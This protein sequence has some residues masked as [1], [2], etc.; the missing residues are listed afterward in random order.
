MKASETGIIFGAG[1]KSADA[2]IEEIVHKKL[3][4]SL[5]RFGYSSL[6]SSKLHKLPKVRHLQQL[7][8]KVS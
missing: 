2:F 5:D 6:S 8:P 7:Y 3:Y 4:P 1:S